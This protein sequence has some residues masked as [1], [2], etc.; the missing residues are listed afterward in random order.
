M[1]IVKYKTKRNGY[2]EIRVSKKIA[3]DLDRLGC[4]KLLLSVNKKEIVGDYRN[5]IITIQCEDTT[6]E[7]LIVGAIPKT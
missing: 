3:D 1:G 4:E 2:K 7:V 6:M 5:Q